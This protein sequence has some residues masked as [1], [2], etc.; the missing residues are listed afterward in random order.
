[1]NA[2]ELITAHQ[3]LYDFC[4]LAKVSRPGKLLGKDTFGVDHELQNITR[5][6]VSE[7]GVDLI[8]L[9]K[10]LKGQTDWRRIGIDVGWKVTVCNKIEDAIIP[11]NYDYYIQ[12]ANDLI[13]PLR[14]I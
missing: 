8:K 7:T 6:Y 2:E 12:R 1:M 9:M 5:Y 3:N 4:C 10:P 13:T 11:I 14:L